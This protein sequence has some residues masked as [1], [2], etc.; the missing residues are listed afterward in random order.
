MSTNF[1]E[2]FTVAKESNQNGSLA[3]SPLDVSD[4]DGSDTR[5]KAGADSPWTDFELEEKEPTVRLN[6]DISV[7][8]NDKLNERANSYR[9]SKSEL[10]RK[11][12]IWALEH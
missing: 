7:A 8:L 12:L 10:V 5:I 9:K 3:A 2:I 6:V 11:I 1:D 4:Q